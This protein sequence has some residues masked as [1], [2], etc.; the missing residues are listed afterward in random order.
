VNRWE[1][2]RCARSSGPLSGDRPD[3]RDPHAV[4]APWPAVHVEHG[5][6]GAGVALI[7]INA[8]LSLVTII[9][10]YRE[11][12]ILRRLRATP[13]RPYTIL[14][15]HVLV[16]LLFTL[17][18]LAAMV[19]AGRRFYPANVDAPL[20]SFAIAL[21]VVTISI[22]TIGFVIASAVPTARFA[23][24]VGAI[25]FYPMIALSGL[26]FPIDTLPPAL[27]WIARLLPLS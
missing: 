3:R 25:V 5:H 14:T 1:H 20:V 19:V 17:L 13:L 26:F 10:I 27:Q 18:T 6:P 12:G 15:A 11:G 23:Q 7:G 21:L 8:V 24:P 22:L 9:S 2:V 16:K 4:D